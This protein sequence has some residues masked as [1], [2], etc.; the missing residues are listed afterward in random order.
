VFALTAADALRVER[1]AAGYDPD[2]AYSRPDADGVDLTMPDPPSDFRF[3]VPSDEQLTFFG[4]PDAGDLFEAAV[5]RLETLGGTAFEVDFTPFRET[6]QL[7]YEGPWVAERLAAIREFLTTR[8]DALYPVTRDIIER[9]AD[10]SAVDTFEAMYER[11]RLE[12]AAAAELSAVDC[13][14]TPTV[15]PA[16]RIAEVQADPVDLNSDLGYYTNY[17]NL[18]DLAA[19]AVPAGMR[20]SGVPFGITLVGDADEDAFLSALAAAF[21]R[22]GQPTGAPTATQDG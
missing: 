15:G 4:S 12:R 10:Y 5:D 7:L 2:D 6:A 20:E 14:V 19:V 3:G 8:P 17:V 9:G 11:K 1:V 16:F 21:T 22:A 18:L 13:L